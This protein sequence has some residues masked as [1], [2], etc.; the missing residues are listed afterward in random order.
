MGKDAIK[1][2]DEAVRGASGRSWDEWEALIDS[3]DGEALSHKE[4]VA[5]LRERGGLDSG[6]WRQAVTN[7]YEK[8]KGRRKVGETQ[9]VGFQVGVQRTVRAGHALAWRV[10]TSADGV[11][12]WLGDGE[13]PT[14]AEGATYR[15]AD[16]STGEVRVV[17]PNGHLRV[18]LHPRGWPRPS[19]IQVRVEAKVDAKTVIG[20][21]Q[22][23]LPAENDREERR[24]H[25]KAALD[26]IE[27]LIGER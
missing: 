24:A 4:I 16:G 13:T 9:D 17:R 23:H 2:S 14:F 27:G 8:L 7:G 6:W 20:F 10:L 22:E 12:A 21:H 18:T 15:L 3:W 19:T 26:A 25:F 5:L 1:I 11:R